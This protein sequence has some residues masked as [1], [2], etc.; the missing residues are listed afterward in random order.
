MKRCNVDRV[1]DASALSQ[2]L[3][4]LTVLGWA[5]AGSAQTWTPLDTPTQFNV[6]VALQLTDGSILIQE[7]QTR[8]GG[9]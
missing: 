6:G 7:F 9:K 3:I 1:K 8:T 4:L 5:G 2:K